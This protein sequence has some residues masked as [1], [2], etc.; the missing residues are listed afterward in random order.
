MRPVNLIPQDQRRRAPRESSGKGA[1]VVLGV[2]GVLLAMV[3]AYVLTSNKV[4]D[5]ENQSAAM[6]AEA[7]RYEAEAAK[8]TNFTD[9]AQ[10]AQTRLQ[11][12]A[13]VART[14]FDWERLMRELSLIMP[15]G[16]WLQSTDASIT[17]ELESGGESASTSTATSSATAAAPSANLVGCT[18]RQSDVAR[19]MVRLRQLHRVDDVSLNESS[20]EQEG[21]A[22]TVDSCGSYYKFDLTVTFDSPDPAGEAP[23]GAN[24]VPASLGGGS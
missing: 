21:Q 17:G 19:M 15:E 8:A 6:S 11:S 24:R 22:A 13:G 20:Q 18:P 4:V 2:L 10:I 16:S 9:F 3:T 7:D 23:R 1:Y 14:R 5:R 12:V